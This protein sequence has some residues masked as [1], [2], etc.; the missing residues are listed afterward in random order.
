MSHV[1][2]VAPLFQLP[3]AG[4]ASR[5]LTALLGE[6]RVLLVFHRGTW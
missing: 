2:T 4:G 5:T 6:G 1:P 3:T